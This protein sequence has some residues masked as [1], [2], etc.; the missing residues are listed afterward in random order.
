[1][2]VYILDSLYRRIALIDKYQSLVWAERFNAFGDIT[3]EVVSTLENK[4]RFVEGVR[5]AMSESDRI[6]T[7]KTVEDTVDAEGRKILKITGPSLEQI[8]DERLARGTL[9]DLTAV[10]T[11]ILTGTP[12]AIA[13]Q[14]F[15]DICVTGILDPGDIISGVIESD[16][17]FPPDTNDEITDT[18]VYE[19]DM[20]TVYK[21]IQN[22]CDVYGMGFRLVKDPASSNL[23]WDVYVGSDRTTGQ[24]SLPAVVLSS[25][26]DNLQNTTE[27]RSIALFKNV[28]YVYSKEGMEIVYGQDVDPDVAGFD[29]RAMFIKMD[30]IEDGDPDASDKMIQ[31]GREELAKARNVIAFDGEMSPTAQYTYGVDYN[32]GDLVEL[33]NDSGTA[34][35]MRVTE[36][37]FS[38]DKEGIRRYPTLELYTVVTIGSWASFN[39]DIEWQDMTTEEWQDM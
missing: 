19:I 12:T 18:V 21:A 34:S 32:L 13:E 16:S 14:I 8:L 7:I 3:L 39:P 30:E 2:E 4:T 27:L 10:P 6:M 20:M 9:S 22:I 24:T 1:M 36:Q 29:R 35:I 23:Y 31:R 15:H 5:L 26:L 11:W 28:A 25:A 38:S 33:R 37:I 17:I